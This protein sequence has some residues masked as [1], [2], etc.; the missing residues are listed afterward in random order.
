MKISAEYSLPLANR[1]AAL[2]I[3]LRS[4]WLSQEQYSKAPPGV[5]LSPNTLHGQL[6]QNQRPAQKP[7]ENINR[8]E[9]AEQ[10]ATEAGEGDWNKLCSVGIGWD[11]GSFG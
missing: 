5:P 6:Q 7:D 3:L 10:E 1:K 11:R 9:T 2:M 4:E 8:A